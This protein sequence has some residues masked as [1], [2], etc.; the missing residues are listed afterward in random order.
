MIFRAIHT[1]YGLQQI[2]KAEATGMPIKLTAMAVGDGGGTDMSPDIKMTQLVREIAG[3]RNKPNAAFQDPA[4]PARYTV[5]LVVPSMLGGFHAREMA[6]YDDAG[7]MFAVAN[8]PL[9]YIPKAGEGAVADAVFRMDFMVTNADIVN[10]ELSSVAVVTRTWLAAN[11]SMAALLPGGLTGQI[12]RKRTNRDGDIEWT[13]PGEFTFVVD[14]IEEE[15]ILLAN[16]VQVDLK[17]T[18]TV[19]LAVYVKVSSEQGGERLA[20]RAGAGGWLPDPADEK[21]LVLGTAYPAGTRVIAVQNEPASQLTGALQEDANLADVED[22]AK[23][24]ENLGV[25]SKEQTEQL[26][27]ASLIAYFARST[28]PSGWLKANGAAVSRTAYAKLFDAIGT[29][30]GAGDG[31][32]TFNLPDLRGE[33]IRGLDDGRGI[34]KDRG[35][36]TAQG[37]QNL[38][39]DHTGSTSIAG[40]H[41]HSF[42][43]TQ[44]MTKAGTDLAAGNAHSGTW[45]N[46]VS[47][48]TGSAGSH[49]HTV[50]VESSGGIEAR[51]RNVALLA[52]IKY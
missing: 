26:A 33:F 37:S 40:S 2:A 50:T 5:E 34:D 41:T 9:V 39:H 47:K 8:L 3:T 46:N 43:D 6:I 19:G 4:D 31:L 1:L 35:L 22:A 27:P 18:S 21:R 14:T 36:G 29:S 49:S 48:S 13:D 17:V 28:A 16:Q 23:A 20:R 52:C 45:G 7:G 51:P 25:Y 42:V 32:N 44:P 24:R 30:W 15:V 10:I 12:P 38:A 11:I